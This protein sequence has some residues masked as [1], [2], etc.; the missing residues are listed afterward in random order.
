MLAGEAC[1]S[2]VAMRQPKLSPRRSCAL[3]LIRLSWSCA[4][5]PCRVVSSPNSSL[6]RTLRYRSPSQSSLGLDADV[7]PALKATLIPRGRQVLSAQVSIFYQDWKGDCWM[8]LTIDSDDNVYPI[9]QARG[10]YK[11]LPDGMLVNGVNDQNPFASG[12]GRYWDELDESGGKLYT[13]AFQDVR[14]APFFEGSTFSTLL[15]GLKGGEAM[16]VGQGPLAGS[17]LVTESANQVSRVT[18]SLLGR[19]VFASGAS[20]AFPEAI[21]SAPDGTLYVVNLGFNPPQHT[22]VT[23]AGVSSPF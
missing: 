14:S 22:K 21:V 23:P 2:E 4:R 20:F 15:A 19:S 9:N 13:A 5:P 7:R 3:L 17:L 18:R 10:F 6:P 8:G 11:I 12:G 16:T 1:C